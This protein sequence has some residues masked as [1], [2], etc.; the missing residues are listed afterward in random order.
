M[1]QIIADLPFGQ[2][3]PDRPHLPRKR[4]WQAGFLV[5]A[6]I[7]TV[8]ALIALAIGVERFI[9]TDAVDPVVDTTA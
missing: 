9:D 7:P 1:T 4:A 3:L 6:L 2:A 8:S 5:L